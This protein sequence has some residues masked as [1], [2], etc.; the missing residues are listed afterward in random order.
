MKRAPF[1]FPTVPITPEDAKIYVIKI[2][3]ITY[4]R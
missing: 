2:A 3:S 1:P 4:R